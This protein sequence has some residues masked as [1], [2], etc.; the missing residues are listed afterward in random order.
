VEGMM[1]DFAVKF[2]AKFRDTFFVEAENGS[3]AM[4]RFFQDA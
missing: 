4:V 2:D 3:D 1:K